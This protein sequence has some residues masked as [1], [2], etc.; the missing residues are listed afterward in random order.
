MV[1]QGTA[2]FFFVFLPGL[3]EP[4]PYCTSASS[5]MLRMRSALIGFK[6]SLRLNV[7]QALPRLPLE[8]A[9][10]SHRSSGRG[11]KSAYD[12]KVPAIKK[13]RTGVSG[14]YPTIRRF[15]IHY[16]PRQIGPPFGMCVYPIDYTGSRHEEAPA[17]LPVQGRN[18]LS[19]V[20][21]YRRSPV[22]KSQSVSLPNRTNG[23]CG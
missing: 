12:P 10:Y 18:I 17:D 14:R 23:T 22:L 5:L 11:S 9:T 13:T 8:Q 7:S 15:K 20:P 6:H 2:T 3:Q 16:S 1:V 4:V 19:E 21:S